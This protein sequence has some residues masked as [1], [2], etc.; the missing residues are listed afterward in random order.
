MHFS[1][2]EIKIISILKSARGKHMTTEDIAKKFYANRDKP[3]YGRV[4]V[5]GIVR[6]LVAKTA[7]QPVKVKRTK[8]QGPRPIEVWIEGAN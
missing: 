6:A 7:K 4:I 2:S 3:E 8:R 5:S 1:P